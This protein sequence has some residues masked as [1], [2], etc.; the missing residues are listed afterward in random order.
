MTPV[1]GTSGGADAG[2]FCGLKHPARSRAGTLVGGAHRW[3]RRWPPRCAAALRGGSSSGARS[4]VRDPDAKHRCW[5]CRWRAMDGLASR[6]RGSDQRLLHAIQLV[7]LPL[8]RGDARRARRTTRPPTSAL[9]HRPAAQSTPFRLRIIFTTDALHLAYRRAPSVG[10]AT[11]QRDEVA[12]LYER[13]VKPAKPC[14]SRYAT[15]IEMAPFRQ[16][17]W[18]DLKSIKRGGA[19]HPRRSCGA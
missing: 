16:E 3:R 2:C 6:Y 12:P 18:F 17:S 13:I 7:Q 19:V 11:E 4:S 15:I 8:K 9:A 14:D 5:G 10:C 1:T